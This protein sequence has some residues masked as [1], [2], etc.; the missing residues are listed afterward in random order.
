MMTKCEKC[1][2]NAASKVILTISDYHPF[3]ENLDD[4]IMT[5]NVCDSC[6]DQTV[7]WWTL[8][9]DAIVKAGRI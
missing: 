9:P 4:P 2:N 3:A 8:I 6:K 1:D 7:Y 5:K